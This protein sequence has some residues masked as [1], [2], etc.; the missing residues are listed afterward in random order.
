MS[1]KN[2]LTSKNYSILETALVF[3]ASWVVKE[4]IK[5]SYEKTVKKPAPENLASQKNSSLEVFAFAFSLALVSAT[6]KIFTRK[7]LT[8][9]WEKE[10]GELP[11]KLQ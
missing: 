5:K 9:K 8:Q 3:G 6:V 7:G 2:K 4:A 10:G 11:K 1:K